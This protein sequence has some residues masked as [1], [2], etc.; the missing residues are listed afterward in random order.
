MAMLARKRLFQALLPKVVPQ[1]SNFRDSQAQSTLCDKLI[2]NIRL[3]RTRSENIARDRGTHHRDLLEHRW[4]HPF[5]KEV[6]ASRTSAMQLTEVHHMAVQ[7][8]TNP[9]FLIP[10]TR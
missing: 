5:N 9:Y 8:P 4:L 7:I 6:S 3:T 10:A 1:V 2:R